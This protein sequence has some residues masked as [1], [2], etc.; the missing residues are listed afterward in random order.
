M[1]HFR[2]ALAEFDK[3][4]VYDKW[5]RAPFNKVRLFDFRGVC[6]LK[7]GRYQEA[8]DEFDMLKSNPAQ[9]K[10]WFQN[11]FNVLLDDLKRQISEDSRLTSEY[12]EILM[13]LIRIKEG[14]SNSLCF[15]KGDPF[16]YGG[17]LFIPEIQEVNSTDGK[18]PIEHPETTKPRTYLSP[19]FV[20]SCAK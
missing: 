9:L 3:A 20:L 10:I 2:I 13:N 15:A 12:K 6:L 16:V 7:L 1:D 14:T 5:L 8:L 11:S 17:N 18:I 19:L 4:G